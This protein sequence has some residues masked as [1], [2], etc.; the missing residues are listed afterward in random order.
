MTAIRTSGFPATLF[1]TAGSAALPVAV[2]GLV[3]A[4]GIHLWSAPEHFALWWAAGAFFLLAALAQ[5][6]GAVVLLRW[7]A[8]PVLLVGIFG[9]LALIALYLASRTTGLP[10]PGSRAGT[11]EPARALDLACLAAEVAAVS[12][13]IVAGRL[14]RPAARS[15]AL[16]M[17]HAAVLASVTAFLFSASSG[18]GLSRWLEAFV[19]WTP[20]AVIVLPAATCLARRLQKLPGAEGGLHARLLAALLVAAGC[21]AASVPLALLLAADA[22]GGYVAVAAATALAASFAGA[23]LRGVSVDPFRR[24]HASA[25]LAGTVASAAALLALTGA[26]GSLAGALLPSAEAQTSGAA[27]DA[28]SYDRSYAV[29][30]INVDIPFNRWGDVDPDGQVY[31]L[32]DDKLAMQNWSRPLAANP[33]N[34]PAGNRR[35]RP[36]PLVIRANAGECVRVDFRNE[37]ND[38]QWSGRLLNPRASMQVRGPSYNVQTSDGGAVGFNDDTSVPNTPG[39]NGI[40][41]FWQAPDEEGLYLFRS[42]TMNSGEEEDAGSVAHGLYGALAVEPAGSTWTDPESGQPIY[43]GTNRHTRVTKASGDPYIDAD[44]NPAAGRSFRESVQLAQDYSEV[45]PGE[46]GHGFNYGTEPARNRVAVNPVGEGNTADQQ[47]PDSIGEETSLSSWVYG[48]P[49][50]VKL[51]SGPGPWPPTPWREDQSNVENCNPNDYEG[52][53]S[54]SCWTSNVTHAYK[55]DPT[56]IRYAMA[57]TAET[58]VFHLHA[59]TWLKN[60][61]DAATF[62]PNNPSSQTLD[63]QTFGPGEAFTADLLFGAGSRA[64]TVG[65]AIFHCHLYPHFAEG[66]WSLLRVHDVREDGT[67]VT[68]DGVNVRNLQPLAD[69]AGQAPPAPTADNPGYPRFIPGE[70]GWRA[71]QAPGGISETDPNAT[72][73]PQTVEREDLREAMRVVAGKALDPTLTPDDP[74][75][76]RAGIARRLAVER[77]V[78]ERNYGPGNE[79]KPGAPLTDPCPPGAREVTYNVSMIQTDIVYNEAGWHDTQGRIIVLDK[80]VDDILAGHKRPEPLFMRVNAGDCVNVNLTNRLPNWIGGDAFLRLAQTNMV[81]LH[82]HLVKFDVLASDGASNGWNYQQAAFSKE[83]ADFNRA[84]LDGTGTCS[85]A[86]CRVP[87]PGNWDPTTE[88]GPQNVGQTLTERWYADYELRTAFNHDHHFA[89]IQQNRGLFGGLIVEPRGMDFRNPRTG[90]FYQPGN[91]NPGAPNCGS[92]C[93]G[94]AAGATMD[95]IGPGA[96]DDFR[97]FGLALQDF[98]SLTRQNG[99]PRLREDVLVG[100][101]EPEE[102][103][104]EDPGIVGV[105]YRNAPFPLRQQKNG[106]P[107]D[108]AYTFSSTVHGDPETPVLQ[109]YSEDPVQMRVLQG[110]QEHQHVFSINGLRWREDPHDPDSPLTNAQTIGISEAFNLRMPRILCGTNDATC[111]GDYLYSSPNVDD[112]YMGMWGIL[113]ARGKRVPQLLPLP[114][115]AS[116]NEPTSAAAPTTT[117]PAPEGRPLTS[118]GLTAPEADAPG[119]PCPPG[120]PVK[121]YNVVAMEAEI[122]YNKH[123]DKDP[124]GLIYALASDE[125]AVRAGEKEPEPL[126]LRANRGDCVEVRLTNKLTQNFLR[127]NG[128]PDGDAMQ[129]LEPDTGTPA[130]LRVSLSPQLLRYDVRGSDGT[131]VGYNRDQTVGPGASRL[132]RWYA[133]AELGATNLLEFG[134]VRGHRHHGLFAGLNIEPQGATYHDPQTGRQI[135]SGVAADIRLPGP[136]NDFREFTAFFQDGLNLRDRNGNPITDPP[137]PGAPP[138]LVAND[139]IDQGEKAMGYGNAPFRHRVGME[140][141][142]A[143]E[144]NPVDG[145]ALA[146]VY[147]SR[148]HGDPDTP[149]FRAFAGDPVRMRVLQGADKQRQNAFQLAGHAWRLY[150]GDGGSPLISTQGGFSVGRAMTAELSSAGNGYPGDYRYNDGMYR[151]HLSGG[152]WGIM[153]VYPRP[154][155]AEALDP[156]PLAEPDDPRAGGH[157]ILPL[158]TSTVETGLNLR[159]GATTIPFRGATTLS[160]TLSAPQGVRVSNRRVTIEERPAGAQGFTPVAGQPEGGLTTGA[161][162]SF[163]LADVRPQKNTEYRASFGGGPNLAATTSANVKVNVR[164]LLTTNLSATSIRNGGNITVSGAVQPAHGGTVRVVIRRGEQVVTTRNVT[165]ANSRYTLR[166]KPPGVGQYTVRVSFAVD[167]DHAGGTGPERRF[168]VVR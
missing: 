61:K 106:R 115:N 60:H 15:L 27:C 14:E 82:P 3:L 55:N 30:A 158:E 89:A 62:D 101:N 81:G 66:F 44:I 140:A 155:D 49:A 148:L 7:P 153:R 117:V 54:T 131:T 108:P 2:T 120:A 87:D 24:P 83:Q 154:S 75:P 147:N 99:D 1:R 159:P 59:H 139:H 71:P 168:R 67:G 98:V 162:G 110:S 150:P 97:E 112:L 51:A 18:T 26:G 79:P 40:S 88:T 107:T 39:Q 90:E 96:T 32:Q 121:R 141:T 65:D 113:R 77:S 161:D 127:H 152:M 47:A 84:V 163:S 132:Y 11:P 16:A 165:L 35:L 102:Y 136:G 57:G 23:P 33:E 157:P 111:A 48:D 166:Y 95:I 19:L 122:Q 76:E 103:P 25:V 126:V 137:D 64:G 134:D 156:T 160:G 69:R 133:D 9:N 93:T 31:V 6:V 8:R 38:R 104:D 149:V 145:Q 130:G 164:V 68:P 142:D 118:N 92:S 4:A 28:S 135:E 42:Q 36:R 72:D 129:P 109:A 56:K 34:D 85:R 143:T 116:P 125:A 146:N 100:P 151:H 37:L 5:G 41:Y 21:A 119:T 114:D 91:G 128:A 73:N 70:F 138:E 167:A 94:D 20:L 13:L 86:G 12:A 46:V 144:A 80:D 45:A 53:G 22:R 78:Q 29:A 50:L 63:S 74:D 17:L 58:H 105:N 43:N 52:F 123:G 10:L 124:Y